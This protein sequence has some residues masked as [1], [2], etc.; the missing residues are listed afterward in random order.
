MSGGLLEKAK[1]QDTEPASDEVEAVVEEM[2]A[3]VEGGLLGRATADGGPPS[4]GGSPFDGLDSSKV[5]MGIAGGLVTLLV[6]FIMYQVVMGFT[7]GG[8]SISVSDLEVDEA[9]NNLR[10]EVYIGTP[11]FKSSPSGDMSM[12]ISYGPGEVWTGSFSVDSKLSWY[13]ISFAD[14]YRNNSRG[15]ASDGSD[16]EYSVSVTLEGSS[17]E[18]FPIPGE[19]SDRTID[20]VDGELSQITESCDCEE[21]ND[22]DHLGVK[23]RVGVGAL[24]PVQS[25]TSNLMMHVDSDYTINAKI[26]HDESAVFS[27]PSVTVDGASASWSGGSGVVNDAWLELEGDGTSTNAFLETIHFID[28]DEFYQGDDGCYTVEITVSQTTPFGEEVSGTSSQGWTFFW[29]YNEDR[30][31]SAGNGPDNEPGTSDDKVPDPYKSPEA[32]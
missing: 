21:K 11:M 28:R 18:S 24:D 29:E 9:E 8:Y 16:I 4:A 25:N 17:S 14:F 12:T 3:P 19:I 1:S 13:E 10:V 31:T 26:L 32:C 22:L 23:F 15:A 2:G 5:K 27:F 30:D 6:L 20:S 7:F